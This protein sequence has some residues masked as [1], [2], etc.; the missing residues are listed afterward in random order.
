MAERFET[1][2]GTADIPTAGALSGLGIPQFG[3]PKPQQRL[4]GAQYLP[5]QLEIEQGRQPTDYQSKQMERLDVEIARLNEELA[6]Y[7]SGKHDEMAEETLRKPRAEI[8]RLEAQ[9]DNFLAQA[10]AEGQE[11]PIDMNQ[12]LT[13]ITSLVGKPSGRLDEEGEE[14][15]ETFSSSLRNIGGVF[16][17]EKLPGIP[18]GT[19]VSPGRLTQILGGRRPGA[20][21][22]A[23]LMGRTG[24]PPDTAATTPPDTTQ[25]APTL[26]Q[27]IAILMQKN[28]SREEAMALIQQN[29]P[30]LIGPGGGM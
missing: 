9:R 15:P 24:A 7:K 1:E 4:E 14:I 3:G 28:Y 8:E 16:G 17:V 20:E 26:E 12:L 5:R 6:V 30:E 10:A 27:A 23:T 11:P 22:Y 2:A 21:D 18:F 29:M 13:R 25:A 19:D